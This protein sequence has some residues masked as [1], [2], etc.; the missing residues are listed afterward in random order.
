MLCVKVVF[1]T[2]AEVLNRKSVVLPEAAY[3]I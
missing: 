1:L 3:D 2:Q